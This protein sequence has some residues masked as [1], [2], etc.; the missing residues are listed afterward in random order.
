MKIYNNPNTESF[1]EL[2]QRPE[3]ALSN[4]MPLVSTIFDEVKAKGDKAVAKYTELFDGVRLNSNSVNAQNI[5]ESDKNLSKELKEAINL[6]YKNIKKFHQAQ[7]TE[8]VKV[9]T[10]PGVVCWQEKKPIEKVGLYVPGGSAALFSSVLMLGIPAQIAGCQEIVLVSPPT[11]K[12]K[13]APEIAYA[14]KLCGITK[15]YKVGG[16]QAIAALTFGT[17]S[18]PKVYKILGP[19]NQ[20]VTAAKQLAT[21]HKVAIDMPAGPSELLVVADKI[22]NP[23]FVAAD[24]L[25]QAEHG[26]DSQVVL[27]STS[28]RLLKQVETS[29]KKQLEKLSRKDIASKALENAIGIY[30]KTPQQALDFINNYAPEHLSIQSNDESFYLKGL[31]NAGSVFIGSLTPESAGDYASGTNHTLPTN[32]FAKQYS[33]V[34]LDSFLKSITYQKISETG[35]QNIG[36]SVEILAEAEGLQAHKNAVSLRLESLK[37]NQ[38]AEK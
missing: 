24:L 37:N 20:Y 34:N 19:G 8:T 21:N 1:T 36:K 33:G 27:V 4:L 28:K 30:F 7:K 14:A 23:A 31:Q 17:Q 15:I 2:T 29:M 32:A 13:L 38:D 35:L 5:Q 9:E 6:A 12:G 22:A 26:E 16:I 18:I 11:K 10:M 25:S 3:Q